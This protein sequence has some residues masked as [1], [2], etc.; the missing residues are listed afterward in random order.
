MSE[1]GRDRRR[2]PWW[3][4]SSAEPAGSAAPN[5]RGSDPVGRQ[6]RSRATWRRRSAAEPAE[7]AGRVACPSTP[8]DL[9]G[10]GTESG[11]R[12]ERRVRIAGRL[13]LFALLLALLVGAFNFDPR[14]REPVG[15]EA[16][17][18]LQALSLGHDLDLAFEA[19]DHRRYR[20]TFGPPDALVL[21]SRDGGEHVTYGVPFLWALWAAPFVR[22]LPLAGPAVAN[23]LLLWLA[24]WVVARSLERRIGAAAWLWTA[25]L[26]FASVAYAYAFFALPDLA[27]LAATALGLALAYG[28][29]AAA[30]GPADL[31]GEPDVDHAK[32]RWRLL[33]RAFAAGALLAVPAIYR[34]VYA[35]LLPAAALA[36]PRRRRAAGLA[37]FAA[38]ALAIAAVAVA[39][40]WTAGGGWSAFG[41]DRRAF[42]AAGGFPG[43]D[44]PADAWTGPRSAGLGPA[45]VA[46]GV[47]EPAFDPRV[48]GWNLVYLLAGRDVGLLPY[49]LPGLLLLALAAGRLR[50]WALAAAVALA[51][52]ALFWLRP[53]NF[54]GGSDALANRFF[55]PLYPALWFLAARGGG[56]A[57]RR[58]LGALAAAALAAPFLLPLWRAPAAHPV[59]DDGRPGYVS[60]VA[61]RLLPFE[62]TQDIP[63]P[64]AVH[65]PLTVSF[66]AGD[67]GPAGDRLRLRGRR[68]VELLLAGPEPL[69]RIVV[70]FGRRA[71]SDLEVL[72]GGAVADLLLRGDGG[73]SFAIDLEPP[74]AHRTRGSA[75]P[76]YFHSLR[77]QLPGAPP[78]DL[79]FTLRA[80]GW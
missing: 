56:R 44:F 38:G 47:T 16:T 27:L 21:Q 4:R 63:V 12:R 7:S 14:S 45:Q 20:E 72:S 60:A 30:S 39:G 1:N 18:R 11:S 19:R 23:A 80:G 31:Y 66:L 59:D 15:D 17:Y 42:V 9:Y 68:P 32:G 65:G 49:F 2:R 57:G 41:G 67:A 26:C 51:L 61:A 43:V 52:A 77:L 34:P 33:V 24:A 25:A 76:A 64:R 53:F 36:L 78:V 29:G 74:R 28:G 73:I 48:W 69:D 50:R 71:P 46:P 37:A 5:G 3:R 55:L 40:Q 75:E 22:V 8:G 70:A 6:P 10:G 58:A 13:V 35:V 79:P 54:F 62:T